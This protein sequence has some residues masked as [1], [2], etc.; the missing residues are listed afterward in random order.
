M[1]RKEYEPYTV[2]EIQ[3]YYTRTQ[4][5]QKIEEDMTGL[6][7]DT[8]YYPEI[9]QRILAKSEVILG[10]LPYGF[11]SDFTY[12]T[13]GMEACT[14]FSIWGALFGVSSAL[15]RR[16]YFQFGSVGNMY[17]NLYIIFIAR[18]GMA[19]K[20]TAVLMAS[21]ILRNVAGL[22]TENDEKELYS[23]PILEG[24]ATP[25]S[26]FELMTPKTIQVFDDDVG[27]PEQ[28]RL[29]SRLVV[30]ADE[31]SAFLGK[32]KYNTGLVDRLTTLY[33][34]KDHDMAYTKKDKAQMLE[35]I[36][37]NFCAGTTPDSFMDSIPV[38]A[39]G[40]GLMSRTCIVHI[41][42]P[43]RQFPIPIVVPNA[44]SNDELTRRLGWIARYKIGK[45]VLSEEASVEYVAWYRSF[46]K[47]MVDEN[48][49]DGDTRLDTILLKVATLI[50]AQTYELNREISLQTMQMSIDLI[51]YMLVHKREVESWIVGDGW[52]KDLSRIITILKKHRKVTRPQVISWTSRYMNA[53]R[54]T[55]VMQT[56]AEGGEVKIYR[57]DECVAK[58][59]GSGDEEYEWIGQ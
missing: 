27:V 25:E 11:I 45:Y 51:E 54:V 28:V 47:R 31:L 53:P 15:Q 26:M 57:D 33:D 36:F 41:D 20:T 48:L 43:K 6:E 23:I 22:F 46:K 10:Q 29:G 8:D 58:P 37:F 1:K 4:P 39:K 19:K 24:K 13:R 50:Q 44:P 3:Q 40:G 16:A 59:I 12:A 38:E 56:L 5:P 35:N 42:E 14:L 52:A 2:G 55:E 30:I 34:C 7:Y 18:P 21:K 9:E 32:Q 17:P 49:G